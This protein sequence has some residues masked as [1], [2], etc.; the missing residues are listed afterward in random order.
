MSDTTELK[1]INPLDYPEW[2]KLVLSNKDY[3]FFHSLAWARVLYETYD[4]KPLYFSLI[5]TNR[6][7]ALIPL[8]E[9]KSILTGKRGV[10]LP[11]TDYCEPI[12]SEGIDGTRAFNFIKKY[13]EN[14]GWKYIEIRGAGNL[15]CDTPNSA[16]FYGHSLN[17]NGDKDQVFAR[18]KSNTQRNIK[19]AIREGVEVKIDNS[20]DSIK[21]FYRLN[22]MT[23][24]EHGLPPQPFHFFKKVYDHIISNDHG[25]VSLA[26]YKGKV[27]AGAI[28]F[29]FGTKAIYKYGASDKTY[30]HLRPS[31]LV[32]WEAIKWCSMNGCDYF[33]FGRTETENTGLRQFKNSWGAE[34]ANIKY[35][36][37]DV[38][39]SKFL[40]E[41]SL[42]VKDSIKNIFKRMPVPLLRAIGTVLYRHVG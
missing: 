2:D 29:H 17:L 10:S 1:V 24:K 27:V 33:C 25:F 8:M 12:I 21:E 9:V 3:S 22:C 11:L 39:K 32:M 23:R 42:R 35:Y 40:L 41:D 4:F 38:T 28:C 31:N 13:A 5:N 30:Q 16:F 19:K 34:E 18:F 20:L 37:Y 7:A 6:L 15:F 26:S 36:K 14:A